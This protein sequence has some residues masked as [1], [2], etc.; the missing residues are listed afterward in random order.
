MT[1]YL[2]TIGLEIHAHLITKTKMFSPV[3]N[4][5][6]DEPNTNVDPII[7]GM[8]GTLPVPNIEAIRKSILVGLA[9]HADIPPFTKW[10]RKHY[11]YPDL[12]KNYQISQFDLPLCVGGWLEVMRADGVRKRINI[13]RAHLEEDAGKLMHEGSYSL[14][15]LNRAGS[16]LLEIV[17]EPD[18]E[19][20]EEAVL[21]AKEIR[22]IL[23][24]IGV[25]T[26]NLQEGVMR[27]DINVSI[28]PE[29]QK[30][31]NPKVE[32]KNVNSFRALNDAILYEIK[33]QHEVFESGGNTIQETRLWDPDTGTTASMRSKEGSADYR[34]FPE[35][36]I[37][38]FTPTPALI[39]ELQA[40]LPKLPAEIEKD[41]IDKYGLS[42]MDASVV[43]ADKSLYE[44]FSTCLALG[45]EKLSMDESV[46]VKKIV[47][48]LSGS[49]L[50]Y[51][52]EHEVSVQQTPLQPD[53]IVELIDVV[54]QEII[55]SSVAKDIF[56]DLL[57]KGA[58]PRA[59]IA[60]RGLEQISDTGAL[61]TAVAEVVASQEHVVATILA[62]K[63][64]AIGF[65]VGLVMK[66]TGG[67]ANPKVVQELL[68]K[69]I[70]VA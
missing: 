34:Y 57:A 30:D 46:L 68:R 12:P 67:K 69:K 36:D 21:Y 32:I 50:S 41:L 49:L 55:S 40:M 11:Y 20:P 3:P 47:N 9:L 42:A 45:K 59:V 66:Q 37:P 26:G 28:R 65:L 44:F 7:L 48:W 51:L 33:R 5:L 56:A 61:E 6:E 16:P 31:F 24:W 38:P 14:V 70:G 17:S 52:N 22:R 58:M 19:T 53:A 64:G 8:P 25:N 15:D 23:T 18:M 4:K 13:T 60:E 27:F 2:T 10:D 62:G 1:T 63:A 39:A 43:T 54:E 29:G 35:P